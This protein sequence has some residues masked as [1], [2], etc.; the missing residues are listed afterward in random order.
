[1]SDDLLLVVYREPEMSDRRPSFDVFFHAQQLYGGLEAP[2]GAGLTPDG[3]SVFLER[4]GEVLEAFLPPGL[5]DLSEHD[6]NGRVGGLMPD[7][8]PEVAQLL[9]SWRL[10]Q[11]H[12][13]AVE[14]GRSSS[15]EPELR[16]MTSEVWSWS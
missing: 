16:Y 12:E 10:D 9:L 4:V 7:H 5:P 2:L 13:F 3:D 8:L 14:V 15:D 6:D 11:S 1:M